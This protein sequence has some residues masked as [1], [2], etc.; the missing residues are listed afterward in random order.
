MNQTKTYKELKN[1]LDEII[2]K[3]QS[4]DI[5]LI[6]AEKYYSEGVK[7]IDILKKL[8][9]ETENKINKLKTYK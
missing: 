1:N 8:L 7:I 3:L 6:E 9:E 2:L 5:D 4:D